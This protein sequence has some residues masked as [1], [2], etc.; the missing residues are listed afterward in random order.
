MD[1]YGP[2]KDHDDKHILVIVDYHSRYF[3]AEIVTSTDFE[4]TRK[5]LEAQVAIMGNMVSLRSD[6][7]RC[8]GA[9]L[10]Q[11][12]AER[13]IKLEYSTPYDPQQNGI[14]EAAMKIMNKART[15]AS[16]ENGNYREEL[17]R[18]VMAHNSAPH[19]VTGKSPEEALLKRRVRRALP[20][21]RA[22]NTIKSL[23]E[24]PETD[25]INKQN[26]KARENAKGV[27]KPTEFREGDWVICKQL[28]KS[29]KHQSSYGEKMYKITAVDKGSIDIVS[30]DGQ[31]FKKSCK[32]LKR[33][34]VEEATNDEEEEIAEGGQA[35][36]K[37]KLH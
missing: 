6:N 33:V 4:S 32:H 3:I 36:E 29:H 23:E 18:A 14:V 21:M 37:D 17:Q 27:K 11:W 10:R 16:V 1:H 2:M 30:D 5:V 20:T 19:S 9:E 7:A 34:I 35:A 24:T 31:K 12:T 13:G 8:F 22:E 28:R 25:A 15:A 26:S